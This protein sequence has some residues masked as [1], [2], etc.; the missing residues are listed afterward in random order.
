M[1]REPSQ[2][3]N[4]DT[5][6][7]LHCPEG[8]ADSTGSLAARGVDV[9]RQAMPHIQDINVGNGII[10]EAVIG[11]DIERGSSD[12]NSDDDTCLVGESWVE[13]S[14]TLVYVPVPGMP[15]TAES[16]YR[17]VPNGC[18]ICLCHFDGGDR[19]IWSSTRSDPHVF[20][21]HCMLHYLLSVGSKAARSR[22][23]NQD[24]DGQD[25]V[26]DATDFAMLCPCCRQSFIS[27]SVIAT[28]PSCVDDL[29][30]RAEIPGA[31]TSDGDGVSATESAV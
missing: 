31:S 9:T 20:H 19:I 3:P 24:A 22:R 1:E 13:E 30:K 11:E 12:S 2:S 17:Y 25:P 26:K 14:S 15:V 21:E 7:G 8:R 29:D 6:K 5:H 16:K 18:A 23:R 4:T 10:P 27:N 28:S